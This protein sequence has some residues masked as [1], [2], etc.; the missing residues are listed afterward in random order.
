MKSESEKEEMTSGF[1]NS[2][3]INCK[4]LE[5]KNLPFSLEKKNEVLL[6]SSSHVR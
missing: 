5:K 1:Q 6:C 4:S 2:N 3:T